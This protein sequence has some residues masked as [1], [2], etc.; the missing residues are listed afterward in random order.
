MK[1]VLNDALSPPKPWEPAPIST[2]NPDPVRSFHDKI[3]HL[4][5]AP[6]GKELLVVSP[7]QGEYNYMTKGYME[8]LSK[9]YSQHYAIEVAPHDVWYIVL[10]Q[11]A[12]LI[13]ANPDAYKVMFTKS[14][15]KQLLLVQKDHATD[16]NIEFLIAELKKN[17][18]TD[19]TIFLPE[20][21]THTPESRIAHMAAFTD[22]MQA[23]YSYGM[24][25]CG[26]PAIHLTGADEDWN[27]LIHSVREIIALFTGINAPKKAITYLARVESV[28]LRIWGTFPCGGDNIDF[29]KN[30]YTQQN[31]GSGGDL[32][33]NGWFG[34]LWLDHKPGQMIKSYHSTV[35]SIPYKDYDT[36]TDY[37]MMVGAFKG[38][39]LPDNTLQA[40]YGKITFQ[41]IDEVP[42]AERKNRPNL[43]MVVTQ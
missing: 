1:I 2:W 41:V 22:G 27:Q 14:D 35:S 25:C 36:D 13:K 39:I 19:S 20:L 29:W 38:L 24:M 16:I 37:V 31:V 40:Q 4:Y 15:E 17:V 23:Y 21:S 30:I 34:E 6:A 10:T 7:M 42:Y 5:K 32:I 11:L 12:E 28:L 9:A 33:V 8:L 3:G 43:T 26:L 18:P